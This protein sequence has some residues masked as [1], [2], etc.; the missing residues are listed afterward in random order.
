MKLIEVKSITRY[1]L[2]D[3]DMNVID[4]SFLK[5]HEPDFIKK[6]KNIEK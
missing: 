3:K 2:I 1:I 6:L 5:P 4:E